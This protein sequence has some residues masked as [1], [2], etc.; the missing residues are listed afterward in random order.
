MHTLLQRASDALAA[1]DAD[2]LEQLC[3]EAAARQV[4]PEEAARYTT[5]LL[6]FQKQVN[7]AQQN[8]VLRQRLFERR[9]VEETQ[10]VP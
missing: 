9:L 6:A 3:H 7:R 10:W 5:A 1:N 2:C 8:I 4:A